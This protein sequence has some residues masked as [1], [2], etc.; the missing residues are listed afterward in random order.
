MVLQDS[1]AIGGDVRIGH[2][3]LHESGSHIVGRENVTLDHAPCSNEVGFQCLTA[4]P[5]Q[6]LRVP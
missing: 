4:R 3:S 1:S 2:G 6:N 5:H